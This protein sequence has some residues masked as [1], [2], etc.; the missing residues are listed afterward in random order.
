MFQYKTIQWD[1]RV[2]G[3][4]LVLKYTS[5]GVDLYQVFTCTEAVER[6]IDDNYMA[7]MGESFVVREAA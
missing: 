1:L 6:F 3:D 7:I 2:N 4:A 5:Q